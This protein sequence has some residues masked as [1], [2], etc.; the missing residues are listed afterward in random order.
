MSRS[1]PASFACRKAAT[2]S[3]WL[4]LAGPAAAQLNDTG[5]LTCYAFWQR[6]NIA[7][8]TVSPATPDPEPLDQAPD[9]QD[10][11]TGTAA[12][13]VLGLMPKLG[14][15]SV[16]G[17]DFTKIANDGSALPADAQIG[18]F[19]GDWACTRDN[20][21]G[22]VWEVKVLSAS[23]LRHMHHLYTWY[24]PDTAVNGGNAGVP[25][26][27]GSCNSTLPA[28]NSSAFVAAVN[29]SQLCGANDWRLPSGEELLS[30]I[31]FESPSTPLIDPL[32]FPNTSVSRHWTGVTAGSS[33]NAFWLAFS[34]PPGL[35]FSGKGSS[36]VVRLVR[37]GL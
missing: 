16:P 37:G 21:T 6:D 23:N 7:V 30:L 26:G 11:T 3:F 4:I 27:P 2:L 35:D 31:H 32:W 22:L 13:D 15:S 12:A 24:E 19:P 10:C 36:H 8:G 14:G 5:Q 18:Q 20:R 9:Q 1:T 25:G 17:F 29:A 28:C 34:N 33:T